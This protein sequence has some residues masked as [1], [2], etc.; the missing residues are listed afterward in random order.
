MEAQDVLGAQKMAELNE[1]GLTITQKILVAVE[2]AAVAF[3][4]TQNFWFK[5][6]GLLML[7]MNKD[8]L[9]L[10]EGLDT[11]TIAVAKLRDEKKQ[12]NQEIQAATEV[13]T[14]I[15]AAEVKANESELTSI[16]EE[17]ESLVKAIPQ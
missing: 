10:L 11:V 6:L 14:E 7:D 3:K 8:V 16:V 9:K 12:L 13:I 5:D 2:R 4:D 15:T 17:A 1:S